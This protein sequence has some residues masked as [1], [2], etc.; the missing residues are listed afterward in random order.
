MPE[1]GRQ[2]PAL[3]LTA[4]PEREKD[5]VGR[6]TLGLSGDSQRPCRLSAGAATS[7]DPAVRSPVA[8]ERFGPWWERPGSPRACYGF[9]GRCV[10][11]PLPRTF[12]V[13]TEPA[14]PTREG[15]ASTASRRLNP[16]TPT[17]PARVATWSCAWMNAVSG[18]IGPFIREH[19]MNGV[20][21]QV[22]FLLSESGCR[23]PDAC[24]N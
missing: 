5:T 24:A 15:G 20:R 16:E 14:I 21:Q 12:R 22:R 10:C 23:L 11:A 4:A 7:C 18:R 1:R 8:H 9:G 3:R 19:L 17:L 2:R 6:F 13:A